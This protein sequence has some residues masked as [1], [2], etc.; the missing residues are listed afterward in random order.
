MTTHASPATSGCGAA[1]DALIRD[2]ERMQAISPGELMPIFRGMVREGCRACPKEQTRV[3][4]FEEKPEVVVGHE[5]V[6]RHFGMPW[7]FKAEDII[8]GG[9]SDGTVPMEALAE[10]IA[11]VEEVARSNGHEAV[12]M[13][14]VSEGLGRLARDAG[15]VPPGPADPRFA[16]LLAAAGDRLQIIARG[17]A[18][19]QRRAAAFQANPAAAR[20]A[21]AIKA[22]LPFEAPV[23][24]LLAGR[25][26]HW[27]SHLPHLYS[28]MMLR[29]GYTVDDLLP[30]V[31][32]AEAVARERG[33]PGVT[34]RDA[35]TVLV[36][37]AAATLARE[38]AKEEA[39]DGC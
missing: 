2:A 15:Y 14:D 6:R 25:P 13:L 28:R 24:D 38:E 12:T 11:A 18:D 35:E 22:S 30:M 32:A 39:S 8:A 1:W 7:E 27:C 26:L 33:H 10:V 31:D 37:A 9:A 34:P 19:S 5:V 3:C 20:N 17:K 21:A 23:H 4:Q 29:L 36:R 16:G